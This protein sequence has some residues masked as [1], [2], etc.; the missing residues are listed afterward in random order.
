M[1]DGHEE[2]VVVHRK[3]ATPAAAGVMGVIP[4]SMSAP[5]Y[6]VLGKGGSGSLN[7]ASHGAGRQLSR[8]K[9]REKFRF[10]AVKGN[11]AK[12]GIDVLSAGSDEAPGAYKDIERVMACQRDLVDIIAR[13]DPKI[14]KMAPE[15]EQAED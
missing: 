12:Q 15:G 1:I 7:S 2:D 3:G 11:L 9:A 5:G 14:V 6:V 13:F 10:S 8:T 4:G